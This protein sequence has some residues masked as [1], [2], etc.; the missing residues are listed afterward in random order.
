MLQTGVILERE[1]GTFRTMGL[2]MRDEI[3]RDGFS[4]GISVPLQ[5]LVIALSTLCNEVHN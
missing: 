2:T 4:R 5:A 3:E 1:G